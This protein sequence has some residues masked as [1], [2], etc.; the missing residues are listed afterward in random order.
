[1]IRSLSTSFRKVM[2]VA[3]EV[4]IVAATAVATAVAALVPQ[5]VVAAVA[6][7]MAAHPVVTA[8][9]VVVLLSLAVVLTHPKAKQIP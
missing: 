2:A 5:A 3:V 6:A 1:M 7:A 9:L 4:P 8:S